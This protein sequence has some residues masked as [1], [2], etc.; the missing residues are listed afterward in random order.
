MSTKEFK[1]SELFNIQTSKSLNKGDVNLINKGQYNFIGRTTSNRGIQGKTNNLCY[2]P[3]PQNSFSFVQVGIS[4]LSFQEKP[5]YSSQ[6][7][8][9][10]TPRFK[11]IVKCFLFF[12]V[13]INKQLTKFENAYIYPKL[14]DVQNMIISLPILSDG[15]PDYQFMENYIR[16]I[17]KKVI[18]RYDR[19]KLL[20]I[21]TAKQ[22]VNTV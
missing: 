22:V 1:L 14:N 18:Q 9:V 16:A 4:H 20:E 19:D 13:V 11:E 2:P 3:N 17:E 21:Q 12:E 5:W 8:F 6:N 7:I 10:L 15:T